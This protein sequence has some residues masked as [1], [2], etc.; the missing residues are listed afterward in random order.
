M[1]ALAT[2]RDGEKAR[3][4]AFRITTLRWFD[5]HEFRPYYA[6]AN[7]SNSECSN[8]SIAGNA[9]VGWF[10]YG[11]RT[12]AWESR[13][14]PGRHCTAFRGVAGV[15]D[16]SDD[17][18]SAEFKIVADEMTVVY[19]SPVL[20]PGS[21]YPFQVSLARPYRIAIQARMTSVAL[22]SPAIGA[23]QLLC[24]YATGASPS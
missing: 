20:T 10:G 1:R 5:L 17:G 19:Q 7:I 14:T 4:T 6:T 22:A 8:E 2:Y 16:R 12:T 15:I 24:D 3:S 18:S 21:A 13:H 9:Y 23:P 11:P